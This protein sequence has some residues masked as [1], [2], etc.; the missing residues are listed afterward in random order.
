M[1][2]PSRP[3]A[4]TAVH[5]GNPA[6]RMVHHRALKTLQPGLNSF[7]QFAVRS[8]ATPQ[9]AETSQAEAEPSR[10]ADRIE[11]HFPAADGFVTARPAGTGSATNDAPESTV[12]SIT[13]AIP[14]T[15][16][17]SKIDDTAGGL[18]IRF[19]VPSLLALCT[20]SA[21]VLRR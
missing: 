3:V 18:D 14:A 19:E 9:S 17:T 12:V 7:A 16:G 15:Q 10:P 2:H 20:L 6:G 1:F 21:L 4:Q 5:H 13:D 8:D 11:D